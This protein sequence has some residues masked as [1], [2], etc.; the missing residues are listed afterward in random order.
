LNVLQCHS[1]GDKR[2]SAFYAKV[3]INGKLDS[4]EN[5]YQLSKRVYG[6]PNPKNWRDLKGKPITHF[7]ILGKMFPKE[8]LS[9]FYKLLWIKYFDQDLIEAQKEN[10]EPLIKYASKFNE[11]EDIFKGKSINCQADVI[12]DI[13]Q[14][15]R[16]SVLKECEE[17]IKLCKN[18][19]NLLVINK[20]LLKS[21]QDIIGHQVNCQGVMGKGLAL[22]IK[23]LGGVYEEYQNFCKSEDNKA[24]LLGKCQIVKSTEGRYVANLFGQCNYN[25]IGENIRRTDYHKLEESLYNL[26]DYAVKNK[27]SVALPY[28]IG[29]ELAGGDWNIVKDIILKVFND[30]PVVIHKYSK[31]SIELCKT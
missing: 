15:G 12:K 13:V 31:A 9:D 29:C 25:K 6:E 18:E 28:K 27:L 19:D 26:K 23:R 21:R 10:R 24:N 1:K 2:F 5:Y 3:I 16:S 17:F 7:N 11:F 22:Q 8:Y 20:D 14:K 4:I 30:Y